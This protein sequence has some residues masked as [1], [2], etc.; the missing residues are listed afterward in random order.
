MHDKNIVHR[1]IKPDNILF[2]GGKI[3]L[4][5]Y[6]FAKQLM[7]SKDIMKSKKYTPYYGAPEIEKGKGYTKKADV[8]SIASL[9]SELLVGQ[10][11][12]QK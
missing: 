1:D 8:Y 4:A 2:M 12:V 9:L 5:D 10:L 6:G 3:I 7:A 11:P